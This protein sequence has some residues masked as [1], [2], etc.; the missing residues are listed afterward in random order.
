MFEALPDYT[1]CKPRHSNDSMKFTLTV[2]TVLLLVTVPANSAEKPNIV[3]IF[4]DDLGY[5]DV[6]C[7][8]QESRIPTYAAIG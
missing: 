1:G 6:G 8:N 4:A 5:G 7:Y 2:L 3:L